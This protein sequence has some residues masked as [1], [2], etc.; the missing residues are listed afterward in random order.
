MGMKNRKRR[1]FIEEFGIT[2]KFLKKIK[3]GKVRV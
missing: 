2:P 1:F 3:N